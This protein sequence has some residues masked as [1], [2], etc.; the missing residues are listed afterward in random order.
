[1]GGLSLLLIEADRPGIKLSRIK[2]QGWCASS[3]ALI[4]MND[5]CVPVSD[6]S[7][8]Y[9]GHHLVQVQR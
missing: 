5:V 2:T 4:A 3:T 1:M 7:S 6:D 9:V 8:P